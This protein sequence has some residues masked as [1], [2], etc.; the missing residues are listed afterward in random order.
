MVRQ[1]FTSW[2]NERPLL[3]DEE[4]YLNFFWEWHFKLNSFSK[5]FNNH[6]TKLNI[7]S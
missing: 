5:Y 2:R 3:R 6:I 7:N 4:R 1:Y